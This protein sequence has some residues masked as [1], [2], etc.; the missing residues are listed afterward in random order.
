MPLNNGLVSGL[1]MCGIGMDVFR[2]IPGKGRIREMGIS[3]KGSEPLAGSPRLYAAVDRGLWPLLRTVMMSW[4][5]FF[6]AS[7]WASPPVVIWVA[8]HSMTVSC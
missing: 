3:L 2:V 5:A 8:Y 6:K 1:L 7:F 4:A